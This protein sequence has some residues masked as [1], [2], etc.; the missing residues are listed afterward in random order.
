M[1][2]VVKGFADSDGFM[3]K[4]KFVGVL[5]MIEVNSKGYEKTVCHSSNCN[6]FNR[7]RRCC[8]S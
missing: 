8:T 6:D 1:K 5:D 3:L 7:L 2:D 4:D